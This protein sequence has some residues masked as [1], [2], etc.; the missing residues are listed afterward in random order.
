M[1][2]FLERDL[3]YVIR[4]DEVLWGSLLLA[5]TLVIHGTALVRTLG[6]S[7]V[8]M[9]RTKQ[10]RPGY[11]SMGILVFTALMIVLANLFEVIVWATFF[12]WK[13]AQPNIFSAFYNSLLNFTTL[14]AG[15]LPPR[16]RLL[17]GMLGICGLLTFAWSTSILSSLAHGFMEE[18]IAQE[19]EKRGS[20]LAITK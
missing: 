19:K 16:W 20:K 15:Y 18:A 2:Q 17:E 7:T 8:L 9:E 4:L 14:Q 13:E 10:D 3:T 6:A 12:V 11:M 5:L 1:H